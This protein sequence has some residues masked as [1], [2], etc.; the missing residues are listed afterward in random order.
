MRAS[1]WELCRQVVRE[2]AKVAMNRVVLVLVLE[3]AV[4]T[5]L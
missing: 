5:S 2:A 3:R 1:V 4:V